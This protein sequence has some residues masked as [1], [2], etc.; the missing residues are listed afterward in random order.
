MVKSST[1]IPPEI[2]AL[3][4][5]EPRLFLAIEKLSKEALAYSGSHA[6][7]RGAVGAVTGE[8]RKLAQDK[9]GHDSPE[10]VALSRLLKRT[11][12][13]TSNITSRL[14]ES[15]PIAELANNQLLSPLQLQAAY[16]IRVIWDAFGRFLVVQGR[17]YEG[18]GG[19]RSKALNPV[20]VMSPDVL[21]SWNRHYRPWVE[22]A[23]LRRSFGLTHAAMVFM[24]VVDARQPGE[25][26]RLLAAP[27]RSAFKVLR[28]ELDDYYRKIR[29]TPKA[30]DQEDEQCQTQLAALAKIEEPS[31]APTHL[32]VRKPLLTL[33]SPVAAPVSSPVPIVPRE[34]KT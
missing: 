33:G 17:N 30:A 7:V 10:V 18:G 1:F 11:D 29:Q 12:P 31:I 20:T 15:D 25:V 16:V 32:A 9:L 34:N 27:P 22:R 3:S 6:A 26:D 23:K 4:V 2:M 28:T 5:I 19:K 24:I 13:R 14:T 8:L 21:N